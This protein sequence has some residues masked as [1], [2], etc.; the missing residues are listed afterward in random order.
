[1]LRRILLMTT[2]IGVS[3]P[4]FAQKI[5][6]VVIDGITKKPIINARVISSSSLTFTSAT[7]H[8]SL[9]DVS[10]LDTLSVNHM[11][12]HPYS[13]R[14]SE[15]T[16]FDTME[17]ALKPKP[18]TLQAVTVRGLRNHK[19]DSLKYRADLNAVFSYKKPT[20]KDGFIRESPTPNGHYKPFQNATSS[21]VRLDVLS[22]IALFSRN[23]TSISKLQKRVLAEEAFHYVDH[24]FSKA[25]I[26]SI[27]PLRDDSLQI[28]INEYRPSVE[29]IKR[30]DEYQLLSYI[31]KSYA[32]FI[33]LGQ[34]KE[35]PSLK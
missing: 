21:V 16:T 7:G 31:K 6:G 4:L 12:Y 11:G 34:Q 17:I 5:N 14:L 3:F 22:A 30:M 15:V 29:D 1:M 9:M 23:K 13:V 35:F 18:I 33:K 27:T 20:L 25:K 8:F 24:I 10:S 19:L 32:D 26:Q 2:M 28:F